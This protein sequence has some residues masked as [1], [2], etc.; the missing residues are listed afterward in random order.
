MTDSPIEIGRANIATALKVLQLFRSIDPEMPVGAAR[1]FLLVASEQGMSVAELK[2][3]S[4][5]A[6]S[7]VSRYH[8]YLG[9]ADRRRG[10]GKGLIVATASAVDSRRKSLRLTPKGRLLMGQIHSIITSAGQISESNAG[11]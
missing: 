8:N 5:S 1:C 11:D 4:G 10:T 3:R 6:M 2:E 7:S 9:K